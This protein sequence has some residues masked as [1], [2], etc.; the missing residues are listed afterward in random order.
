MPSN[1]RCS[2]QGCTHFDDARCLPESVSYHERHWRTLYD[3]GGLCG[4][5]RFTCM[6][7]ARA[8]CRAPTSLC[9][10]STCRPKQC[11][12]MPSEWPFHTGPRSRSCHRLEG[13]LRSGSRDRF[14][15]TELTRCSIRFN[16]CGRSERAQRTPRAEASTVPGH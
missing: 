6:S 10:L 12:P 4:S 9:W 8:S 1:V 3:D 7:F 16:S 13:L 11:P 14:V 5:P 2:Y 15:I